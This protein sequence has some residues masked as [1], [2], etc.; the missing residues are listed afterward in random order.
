MVWSHSQLHDRGFWRASWESA[1]PLSHRRAEEQDGPGR[2]LSRL[3][4][5]GRAVL[6]TACCCPLLT[7]GPEGA[8][9]HAGGARAR[10]EE[11]GAAC[12]CREEAHAIK[13][14]LLLSFA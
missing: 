3:Q 11:Q 9:G 13:R 5:W 2:R 7:S 10:D 14:L 4:Q 8:G 1:T 6:A 12:I